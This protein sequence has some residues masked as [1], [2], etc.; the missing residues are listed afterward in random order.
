M[1]STRRIYIYLFIIIAVLFSLNSPLFAEVLI[2]SAGEEF[3]GQFID[4]QVRRLREEK[5]E[6]MPYLDPGYISYSINPETI[7][8]KDIFLSKGEQSVSELIERAKMV[9]TPAK[10]ASET[11]SLSNRRVF[12]AVRK[13][14]PEVTIER[15]WRDGSLASGAV[16]EAFTSGSYKFSVRQPLFK[17]GTLWNALLQEKANL[18]AATKEYDS[19]IDD[20]ILDLSE[21]YFEYQRAIE[22]KEEQKSTIEGLEAFTELSS[23]KF[24]QQMIS[25]IEHLNV[26]SLFG[27]VE[28]DYETAKQEFELAL[29]D[30]QKI[31]NLSMDD[32]FR[33]GRLYDLEELLLRENWG[34]GKGNID[35]S[36]TLFEGEKSI[37]PL[38]EL[39]DLAY[40]HR[41]ELQV[42]SA[43]LQAA[44]LGER[45]RWGGFL[46]TAD[47]T[48]EFGK[49]GEAF[50]DAWDTIN[51][52]RVMVGVD[53]PKWHKEWR[54]MLEFNWNLA[55]NKMSY[56]FENNETAPSVSTFASGLGSQ[57]S[58]NS[59]S[60]GILDGLDS[61]V[62]VKQAEVD[63]LNRIVGLEKAEK[64]VLQDVK[65][66]YYD[67]QKA[68]IQIRSAIKRVNWRKR[69]RELSKHRL[70][71]NELEISE[72]LQSEVDLL[73]EK[74]DLH[75]ALSDYFTARAKLN[76]A[77]GTHTFLDKEPIN[78]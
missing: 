18:E 77:V 62:D 41:A 52:E 78:G 65:Q 19:I 72:Y 1:N 29:L 8:E 30:L 37:P 21:A 66:A 56:S 75:K 4:E 11:I 6:S 44:R 58:R 61:F 55:G 35:E 33:I 68:L 36:V 57:T 54:L 32:E 64:E 49:L 27:Q 26:Q 59:L 76:Y 28:F 50:T 17:G 45:I 53:D 63:K 15:Q 13:L 71:R 25:E 7:K 46:P 67:Y 34:E 14:F 48:M 70:E 38:D 47:L 5:V 39:I 16:K 3:R 73:R 2:P 60:I 51:G 20:L 24:S 9:N 40:M 22:V 43:K 31:L 69:L 42:E 23:E 10:A 12:L 74:T